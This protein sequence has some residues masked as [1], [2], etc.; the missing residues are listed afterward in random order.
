MCMNQALRTAVKSRL[1][2]SR[3]RNRYHDQGLNGQKTE[4]QDSREPSRKQTPS[5]S[6][7]K[8]EGQCDKRKRQL[9][10]GQTQAGA[11]FP[12]R[13]SSR[14]PNWGPP[15]GYLPEHGPG[16]RPRTRNP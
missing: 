5:V 9:T 4:D 3:A 6:V 10:K 15:R 12:A 13:S 16:S 2:R 1:L 8:K 7:G 11:T 14:N